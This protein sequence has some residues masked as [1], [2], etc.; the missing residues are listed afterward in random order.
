MAIHW[1]IPFM[2]LRSGTLYTVNIYDAAYSGTPITLIGGASPFTTEESDTEDQFVPIRTQSGYLRI[3][4]GG[5]DAQGNPFN[6]RDLLPSTDTDRPVTLTHIE[7]GSIVTDWVG[8]MQAQNFGDVLYGNPQEREFPIQCPLSV[9][10][11]TDINFNQKELQNFAYLLKQIVDCI[12]AISR[13]TSFVIQGGSDAQAWLLKRIDWQNFSTDN[14]NGAM[15]ARYDMYRCL[16]DMCTYWGWT[17]RTYKQTM[18]MTS[19]DDPD[20]QSFLTLTYNE[21]ATMAG[22]VAAGSTAAYSTVAL[23]GDIFAS[24]NNNDMRQRGPHKAVVK[25]DVNNVEE[26]IISCESGSLIKK[27][28]ELGWQAQQHVGEKYFSYT[29]PLM[30]FVENNTIGSARENYASFHVIAIQDAINDPN[31]QELPVIYI[32][33]SFTS[34]DAEAYASIECAYEHGFDGGYLTLKGDVYRAGARL[35]AY[36]ENSTRIG[37]EVGRLTMYVRIGLG[38]SRN[39]AKWFNGSR[40]VDT[41]TAV[42]VTIGNADNI[43][44][45]KTAGN[46]SNNSIQMQGAGKLFIDFL[47][48]DDIPVLV[49]E[50][51]FDIAN[52]GVSFSFSSGRVITGL[53]GI[54][55][56][57]RV[58]TREYVNSNG[59]S[60]RDEYNADCIYASNNNM[61]YGFGLIINPDG[62]F[63]GALS[64]NG[65]ETLVWPEQHLANRIAS[66]WATARRMIKTELRSNTIPVITPQNKVTLD[67]TTFHPIAIS[68][69]WRDDVTTLTLLEI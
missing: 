31:T 19:V 20:E 36:D 10:Q 27:M 15:V 4:D 46:F 44:R 61:L 21:L 63:M 26:D 57:G 69:D 66:Y 50:R 40:W 52:V 11:G 25:V 56:D 22:G 30:S 17:A 55:T 35:V 13:P 2:S 7:N 62:S 3:I 43:L 16:Q 64:Y 6:W 29:N 42:K 24:V 53:A 14:G 23:S 28:E 54:K 34:A 9:T 41:M 65:S 58:A 38:K 5:K 48:S 8:T 51:A 33:K 47:G 60:V 37:H 49:G 1:Q 68:H 12:P 18:F 32:N 39:T 59:N 67:S 45:V